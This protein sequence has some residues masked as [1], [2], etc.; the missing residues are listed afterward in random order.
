MGGSTAYANMCITYK[1]RP[2][3]IC[4]YHQTSLISFNHTIITE[5]SICYFDNCI[6]HQLLQILTRILP[7]G[8]QLWATQHT[9]STETA[10]VATS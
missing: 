2:L 9:W 3:I 6:C 1:T 8:S 7:C 10:E 4:N 5:K